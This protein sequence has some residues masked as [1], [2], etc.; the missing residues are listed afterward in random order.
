MT[1]WRAGQILT[2]NDVMLS[3]TLGTIVDFDA[4]DKIGASKPIGVTRS[5]WSDGSQTLFAAADEVY[6][7]D[8]WGTQFYAPVGDNAN[9]NGMFEYSVVSIIAATDGTLV[10]IDKDG[11]GIY[12]TTGV[13]LSQGGTSISSTTTRTG[14]HRGGRVRSNA[15]H[16]I[17]VNLMTANTCAG[18]ESRTYPLLPYDQWDSSY[19][20]PVSTITTQHRPGQR[21]R[22]DHGAPVQPQCRLDLRGVRLRQR[23]R[24]LSHRRRQQQQHHGDAGR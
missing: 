23:L 15:G 11:N 9:L 1:S 16:P 13:A 2:L 22:A 3:T 8:R 18:Y 24:R 20:L 14:W 7:V 4:R 6:P 17:Q 12:E 21:R 10:D 19:Y 5:V